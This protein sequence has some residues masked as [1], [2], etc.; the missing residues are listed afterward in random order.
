MEEQN[1]HI[2]VSIHSEWDAVINLRPSNNLVIYRRCLCFLNCWKWTSN[3]CSDVIILKLNM[4]SHVIVPQY[5]VYTLW[6]ANRFPAPR[7]CIMLVL[8][9][10]HVNL[11]YEHTAGLRST[12]LI[13][14]ERKLIDPSTWHSNSG[15]MLPRWT[16]SKWTME[17]QTSPSP[18]HRE[19]KSA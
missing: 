7:T 13:L 15:V 18:S 10:C 8:R 1:N 17:K 9:L 19:V 3:H 16:L 4:I 14:Q 12:P 11:I 5:T 2:Q 6:Q